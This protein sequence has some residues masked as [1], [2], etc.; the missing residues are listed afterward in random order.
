MKTI[1]FKIISLTIGLLMAGVLGEFLVRL[2]YFGADT[3]SY[4]K[5]NSFTEMGHSGNVQASQSPKIQYELKPNLDRSFKLKSFKTNSQG[6]RDQEYSLVKKGNTIRGAIIGDSFS[7]GTGVEMEEIYHSLLEKRLN[8]RS[9]GTTYELINFAVSGYN[10]LHY[11]G[12]LEDKIEAYDPDFILIGFCGNNDFNEPRS[13]QLSG[14][15]F[16]EKEKQ[17]PYWKSYFWQMISDRIFSTRKKNGHGKITKNEW[18]HADSMLAAFKA[19]SIDHEIPTLIQYLSIYKY[20]T[21]YQSLV[22]LTAKH[23]LAL[24]GHPPKFQANKPQYFFSHELDHH[25]NAAAHKI[26]EETLYESAIF[27]KTIQEI[28]NQ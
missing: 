9:D 7:M 28:R 17:N 18:I 20:E 4:E 3:F 12:L 15:K 11:L 23:E 22:E 2:Y 19:Y 26:F 14:E 13:N 6:L 10:L 24:I 25:P 21:S 5:V 27:Q 8:D 1:Y 16:Q